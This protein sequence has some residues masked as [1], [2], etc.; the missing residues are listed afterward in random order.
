MGP[1]Q[2]TVLGELRTSGEGDVGYR[3]IASKMIELAKEKNPR[4][5]D[6][7]KNNFKS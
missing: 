5:F 2:L 3:R 4:L 6:H 7:I 1:R